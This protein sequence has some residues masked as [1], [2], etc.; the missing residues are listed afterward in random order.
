MPPTPE[1][2]QIPGRI[3]LLPGS[4]GLPLYRLHADGGTADIHLH[5][6]HVT[7]FTPR[8]HDPVL[9]MSQS[10][11]F[12]PGKPIRGGIPLCWP[13]FGPHPA[14]PDRPAHGI[15]RLRE[16]TP[17]DSALLHDGRLRLRLG[18]HP[19][20]RETAWVPPTLHA[21]LTLTLG[22]ALELQLCTR[23]HGPDPV[24][25]ED[26]LHSYFAVG[27]LAGVSVTG[28]EDTVYA[29]SL[30]QR[31]LKIQS[32][33]VTFTAETDRVYADTAPATEIIDTARARRIRIEKTGS[34]STV[35]WNPWINKSKAMPDFGDHEWPHMCCV[36]TANARDGRI[37]LLPGN[38]H[39]TRL[40]ISIP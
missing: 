39:E 2:L 32:G 16:W 35:V 20:E 13:W 22:T 4:G 10:S 33:P 3:T 11:W 19:R 14:D 34:R 28:L 5:G 1:S 24:T 7:A 9:W 6:A 15:A 27:D 36:E 17:I 18:F 40:R 23:N 29:D 21:E 38:Q 37:T 30:D 12:A 26:A 8:G 25:F 31:R